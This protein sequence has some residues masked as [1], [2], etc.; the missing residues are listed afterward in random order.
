MAITPPSTARELKSRSQELLHQ[1]QTIPLA[2][3]QRLALLAEAQVYA[4]LAFLDAYGSA[5][6]KAA[7]R[8]STRKTATPEKETSDNA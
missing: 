6:T 4:S 1:A 5:T 2:S 7:P 3:P 8:K